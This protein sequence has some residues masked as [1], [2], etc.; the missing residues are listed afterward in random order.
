M[1]EHFP[2]FRQHPELV[3]LDSASTSQKLKVVIERERDFYERENANVHRGLYALSSEAT[4]KYEVVRQ[5]VADFIGARSANEIAFTKGSTESIN[6]VANSIAKQ[7]KAGDNV[8]VTAM[9]HHA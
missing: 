9:E 4:Q 1:K 5:Q 3:Y 8:V 6:I 7:L 2:I